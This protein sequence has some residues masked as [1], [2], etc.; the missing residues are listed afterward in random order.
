MKN[1]SLTAADIRRM[2]AYMNKVNALQAG[3][4]GGLYGVNY[5][6]SNPVQNSTPNVFTAAQQQVNRYKKNVLSK[7]ALKSKHDV[8]LADVNK[9]LDAFMLTPEHKDYLARTVSGCVRR[10][11]VRLIYSKEFKVKIDQIAR[12]VLANG[13]K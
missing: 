11:V 8:L 4:I 10:A 2:V 13:I 5:V 6:Q 3:V 12:E 7:E 1:K 9:E